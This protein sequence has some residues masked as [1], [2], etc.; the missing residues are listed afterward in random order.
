MD[1]KIAF[2]T[3]AG[4]FDVVETFEATDC[5]AANAYAEKNHAGREWYVLDA[6]G[7]NINA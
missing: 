6:D 4:G 1:F 3:E 7:D 2:Q 5:D